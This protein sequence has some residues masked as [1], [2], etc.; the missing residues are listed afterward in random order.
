MFLGATPGAHGQ[1]A[2]RGGVGERV[3]SQEKRCR[4]A[5]RRHEDEGQQALAPLGAT[6]NTPV[7]RVTRAFPCGQT[8]LPDL[9]RDGPAPLQAAAPSA[10]VTVK[11]AAPASKNPPYADTH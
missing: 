4:T 7:L 1:F 8:V 11:T 3:G 5:V 10:T 2:K 9:E 6:R